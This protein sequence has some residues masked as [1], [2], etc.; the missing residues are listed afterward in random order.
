MGVLLSSDAC[1]V[2]RERKHPA[3]KEKYPDISLNAFHATSV[4]Y[5]SPHSKQ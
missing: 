2:E 4:K 5:I 3:L 1:D